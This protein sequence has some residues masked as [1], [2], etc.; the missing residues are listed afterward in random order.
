MLFLFSDDQ[1]S[2]TETDRPQYPP[3]GS[4]AVMPSLSTAAGLSDPD[5]PH[6][7]DEIVRLTNKLIN[8]P[9]PSA[10]ATGG[11][12][13]SQLPRAPS[14]LTL[15]ARSGISNMFPSGEIG[16]GSHAAEL[17]LRHPSIDIDF[18]GENLEYII[19]NFNHSESSIPRF[20][21]PPENNTLENNDRVCN[22]IRLGVGIIIFFAIND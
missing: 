10:P 1:E 3:R 7:A 17:L 5:R 22:H 6:R 18:G 14:S 19:G 15:L 13:A 2:S 16:D 12:S 11:V 9:E 8:P 20:S 21:S 4:L